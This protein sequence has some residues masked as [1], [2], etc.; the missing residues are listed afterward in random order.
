MSTEEK[1]V[2]KKKGNFFTNLIFSPEEETT[3]ESTQEE[4]AEEAPIS[5]TNTGTVNPVQSFNIPVT[6]DGVF[7]KNFNDAFQKVLADNDLQGIDYLELKKALIQMSGSGLNDA[8][9]FQTVFTTLRV[10]D[11]SLS[12]QK[13]TSS[14]DYYVNI[15]K[16]EEKE[17]K[18]EMTD[19]VE[20]EINARRKEAADLNTKNADLVQQIQN[21]NEQISQNQQK[22]LQLNAEAADFEAK[23][24]QTHK[25]F[26]VTLAHMISGLETDKVKIEQLI[27]ED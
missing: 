11:A 24:G 1:Q 9:S 25:N 2:K 13:L 21:I 3:Q 4:K 8:M 7:D 27:K 12:K 14:I 23:I 18:S 16:E 6:G 20:R 15:L 17:F 22:A 26:T 5:V 19:N 10:G